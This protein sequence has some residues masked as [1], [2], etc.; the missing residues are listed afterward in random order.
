[1]LRPRQEREVGESLTRRQLAH[2]VVEPPRAV[3]GEGERIGERVLVVVL[4]LARLKMRLFHSR[5]HGG[6]VLLKHCFKQI[7][8][9]PE[10]MADDVP[11]L[12]VLRGRHIFPAH[13]I[14]RDEHLAAVDIIAEIPQMHEE[15]HD[16]VR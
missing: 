5:S 4:D 16:I 10:R 2:D 6:G 1:M 3:K 13:F 9:G 8:R 11:F 7:V 15:R 14:V 12:A